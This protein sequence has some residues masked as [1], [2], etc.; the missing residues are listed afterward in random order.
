MFRIRVPL[1]LQPCL[2]KKEYRRSLGRCYAAEAK[3][4][5]LKMAAAALEV[6]S[7]AR[8]ALE[9]R[10][11]LEIHRAGEA[12]R[13]RESSQ[14]QPAYT[15][16]R[17]AGSDKNINII[18]H[19]NA[20]F[21]DCFRGKS[22]KFLKSHQKD[23]SRKAL[24][25]NAFRR[26]PLKTEAAIFWA[27]QALG[28]WHPLASPAAWTRRNAV[29][30]QAARSIVSTT[31]IHNHK[32]R[33]MYKANSAITDAYTLPQHPGAVLAAAATAATGR[34]DNVD[35]H[36]N[37]AR[38]PYANDYDVGLDGGR[39]DAGLDGG[40]QEGLFFQGRALGSLTDDDI[41]AIAD[42]WLLR[43]LQDNNLF[44]SQFG[45][46]EEGDG[47]FCCSCSR[48]RS[49][50]GSSGSRG[51]GAMVLDD[52]FIVPGSGS[53]GQK[54]EEGEEEEAEKGERRSHKFQGQVNLHAV[55]GD[56][57]TKY[58]SQY[59]AEA[60][61][62]RTRKEDC[63][64]E[65]RARRVSRY[66]AHKV[67]RVLAA[68]G[69]VIAAPT[70][71][72]TPN[73]AQTAS[74]P[75]RPYLKACHEF[76]KSQMRFYE[77][78][79][80]SA[81]GDYS[82]YDATI[83]HLKE[84]L[85][86]RGKEE[87]EKRGRKEKEERNGKPSTGA[88]VTSGS[89]LKLS[90]A[91]QLFFTEKTQRG[92]WSER[93]QAKASRFFEL[94]QAIIDPKGTLYVRDICA[95]HMRDYSRVLFGI[96]KNNGAG[97]AALVREARRGN[98]PDERRLTEKTIGNHFVQIKTFIN[99]L[100]CNEYHH[101]PKITGLLKVEK[102]KQSHENRD[103]F[104][105]NDLIRLFAPEDFLNAGLK[106][107]QEQAQTRRESPS[108]A[109]PDSA[110]KPSRFWVP[111]LGLCTGARLEELC[112]LQLADIVAV[113]REG[114]FRSL[115]TPGVGQPLSPAALLRDI[116]NRRETLCIYI[117]PGEGKS[118]KTTSSK[119]FTPIS[120]MLSKD[121][122]F[123][124]YVAFVHKNCCK[125]NPESERVFPELKRGAAR[126]ATYGN[127]VS[128]WFRRY[129]TDIGIVAG[130]DG[131]KKD[132]HSFRHTVAYWCDQIGEVAE[133]PA[134]RYLGHTIK[135]MTF[136]T[137]SK[138]T[139]PHILHEQITAPLTD[140]FRSILD[141]E[142]LKQSTWAS[143]EKEIASEEEA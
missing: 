37:H 68:Q 54:E 59:E 46:E 71:G 51:Y 92:N 41:R 50:S 20:S 61:S 75:A 142:G 32:E 108:Y 49:G 64:R 81:D 129:R 99:W 131:G 30:P 82:A 136:G 31:P 1:E 55:G 85:D 110:G 17:E 72:V 22:P 12:S 86:K 121:L 78:M 29:F 143:L 95:E 84:T 27:G 134:A 76:L 104:S 87:K 14:A 79:A 69:I 119:R 123:L 7:F 9:A 24:R 126:G 53:D 125:G 73:A 124:A 74:P 57:T 106:R 112:Q 140:Y 111:L 10:Q 91:L 120:Q 109:L 63:R 116:E 77:I 93:S 28:V 67:E 135:G 139:A 42:Q 101:N 66:T 38:A 5:A 40:Q 52:G 34:R 56:E 13:V 43:A 88:G 107:R 19:E 8:M 103:P 102:S 100:A 62:Y 138:D 3:L 127:S 11:I 90:E 15:P 70:R 16:F 113:D 80:Q 98:V 83:E 132:F 141:V 58:E 128:N 45:G 35:E 94:F 65:L 97:I 6:F 115:F 133:K 26:G 39:L 47:Y 23:N 33:T 18:F 118:T 89:G 25:P 21:L 36:K 130:P 4:L 137:Y 60:A 122:G 117:R 48:Q 2:G 114:E 96:S 105:R 44:L